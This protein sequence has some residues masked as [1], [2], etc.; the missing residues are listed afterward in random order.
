VQDVAELDDSIGGQPVITA[1]TVG[2]LTA[3][4]AEEEEEGILLVHAYVQEAD[5]D[6]WLLIQQNVYIRWVK[7]SSI[8]CDSHVSR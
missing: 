1:D 7:V 6:I 5:L 8:F 2:L 3:T 4:G